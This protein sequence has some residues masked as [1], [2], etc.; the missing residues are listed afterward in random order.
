MQ[1]PLICFD[2][3]GTLVDE[4]IYI[5]S[6]FHEHFQTDRDKRVRAK[7][8]FYAGRISYDEWFANDLELLADS[9]ADRVAMTSLIEGLPPMPGALETVQTLSRRGHKVAIISGSVDLVVQTVFPSL[10]FDYVLI[11]K[12]F[13]D[14]TGQLSGG[15][16]TPYDID[17]KADGLRALAAREGLE[18]S[19]VA[20]VGDNENDV[21]VA[22]AAGRAI[23]FNCKSDDLAR[24]AYTVVEEHDLRAVL[25]LLDGAR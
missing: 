8:D 7:E 11:N 12:L 2:L 20:F 10:H 25:P 19:Q 9:G 17:R 24:A 1:F 23:A 4:T 22:R 18:A 13:F 3:D 15:E 16:P 6:T 14:E 5:W 21:A